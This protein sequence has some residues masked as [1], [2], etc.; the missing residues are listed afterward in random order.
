[1]MASS[2]CLNLLPVYRQYRAQAGVEAGQWAGEV[3]SSRLAWLATY[4]QES[5]GCPG[6]PGRVTRVECSES[7]RSWDTGRIRFAVVTALLAGSLY[8]S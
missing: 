8:R 7:G 5:S 2:D 6:R 3:D 1:M 4:Q